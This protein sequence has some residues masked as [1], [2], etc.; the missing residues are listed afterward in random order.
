MDLEELIKEHAELLD[1]RA[2]KDPALCEKLKQLGLR[3][4]PPKRPPLSIAPLVS[5]YSIVLLVFAF[6]N[7]QFIRLIVQKTPVPK[8][9]IV[10]TAEIFQPNFPGSIS[11]ILEEVVAWDE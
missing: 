7:F 5:L 9:P 10:E 2:Q 8:Q 3:E 6:L 4:K 1:C 11:Q